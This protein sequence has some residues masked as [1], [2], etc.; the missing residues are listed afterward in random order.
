MW[1]ISTVFT[2]LLLTPAT[3]PVTVLL[4]VALI[5]SIPFV[6]G[7]F[8]AVVIESRRERKEVENDF[9]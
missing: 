5:I 2:V 3:A 4:M 6:V 1:M 8:T 9:Y 7:Y